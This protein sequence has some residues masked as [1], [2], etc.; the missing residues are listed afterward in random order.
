MFDSLQSHWWQH[1]RLPCPSLSPGVCSN[2][3]PLSRW[4]YPT[5]SSSAAHFS[6]AFNLSQHQGL[7]QWVSSLHQ[8][9]KVSELRGFYSWSSMA[10]HVNFGFNPSFVLLYWWTWRTK[11]CLFS[12]PSFHHHAGHTVGTRELA[13]KRCVCG[14]GMV[15]FSEWCGVPTDSSL[16]QALGC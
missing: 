3:C 2:S 4:C 7:F 8:M 15:V 16:P 10:H 14:W 6:F 9:A 11:S 5:I 1:T 12:S 13:W